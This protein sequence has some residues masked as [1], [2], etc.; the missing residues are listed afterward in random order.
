M[1]QSK[2]DE[3]LSRLNDKLDVLIKVIGIQVGADKSATERARLLKLA[4]MDNRTIAAVLNTSPGS[5]S[6]MTANLR[7]PRR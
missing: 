3:L 5:I 2:T 1:P 4:G 6:V 7:I